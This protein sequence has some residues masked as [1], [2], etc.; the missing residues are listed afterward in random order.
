MGS[1]AYD[2][3]LEF[4]TF[5]RSNALLVQIGQ[6]SPR[7]HRIYPRRAVTLP[8]LF[9]NRTSIVCHPVLPTPVGI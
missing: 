4:V 6:M 7:R 8:L 3:Q 9:F 5:P 2:G 1:F